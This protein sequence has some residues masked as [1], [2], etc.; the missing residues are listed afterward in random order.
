MTTTQPSLFGYTPPAPTAPPAGGWRRT[1]PPQSV[2]AATSKPN[3]MRW[4]SQRCR[5][6]AAYMDSSALLYGFTD[7]QA[8]RVAG[9]AR[10]KET[11]RISELLQ[12]GRLY[13]SGEVRAM[14]SGG[15][16]RVCF[17]TQL[18]RDSVRDAKR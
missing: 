7:E 16:G 3:R 11:K 5:L 2:S 9:I 14:D 10:V 4:A 18:G 8:G 15:D 12:E 17:I 13:D 6:L 1:D